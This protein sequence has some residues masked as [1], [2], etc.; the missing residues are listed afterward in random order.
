MHGV[1]RI[2]IPL[3]VSMISPA[4]AIDGA[5]L[6]LWAES[7]DSCASDGGAFWITPNGLKGVDSAC[8]TKRVSRDGAGWLV[9][10]SCVLDGRKSTRISHFHLG[11][12]GRL[13]EVQDGRP[14]VYVR[15]K[16]GGRR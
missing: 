14:Y 12:D 2:F 3:L 16:D 11:P 4:H 7:L 5:F 8:K 15:C 13:H 6:G 10:L 1:T 9:Q